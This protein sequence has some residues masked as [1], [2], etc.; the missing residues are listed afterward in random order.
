M[1]LR[2]YTHWIFDMDGTLTMPV[3]DFDLIRTKL[4]V[5]E[6]HSIL[7]AI[8][9]MSDG[10]A[11]EIKR[12]LNK[13]ETDLANQALPQPG[14]ESLLSRLISRGCKVGILT[15]NDEQVA[16]KTLRVAGLDAYFEDGAIIG[17]ET[18]KPK[19]DPDGVLHLMEMW[20]ATA[21]STLVV[22][23]Y[24]HDLKAGFAA[25]ITTVHFD[26]SEMYEWPEYTHHRVPSII[27]LLT[28]I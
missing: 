4:G 18:C 26:S 24:L 10:E 15:R 28:M 14:I 5:E 12:K 16:R 9:N 23:D 7:E 13:I 11:A 6:A 19:P 21:E 20:D 17:R 8:E 2:D 1:I 22:G 3:H 25:G 27:Q